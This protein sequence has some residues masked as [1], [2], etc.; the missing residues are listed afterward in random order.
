MKTLILNGANKH[1]GAN[2][3]QER[4]TNNKRCV[5][6]RAVKALCLSSTAPSSSI[7]AIVVERAQQ[8]EK[9]T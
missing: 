5:K 3:I 6:M 2:F 1:P 8:I 9:L 7:E 4:Q